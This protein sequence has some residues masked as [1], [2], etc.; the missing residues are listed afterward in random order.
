MAYISPPNTVLAGQAMT[1]D[2]LP[3]TVPAGIL[4]VTFNNDIATVGSLGVVQVGDNIS[5][6]AS[7]VISAAAPVPGPQGPTGPGGG[8]DGPQGPTGPSGPSGGPTGPEGPTGPSG[9]TGP[10]GVVGATGPQGP[11]G[12]S[13]AGATGPQGPQG[14]IGPTGPSGPSGPQGVVGATGPQGPT[15]QAGAQGPQGVQ[16]PSGANGS[17][18][19]Q[20]PTGQAGAQGP[21]G[22]SGAVGPTGPTASAQYG[23]FFDTTTQTNPVVNTANPMTLNSTGDTSGIS[24]VSGSRVTVTVTG[25]YAIVFTAS[26]NKTDGGADTISFWLA[27]NGIN[28]SNS[29][30]DL[31]LNSSIDTIFDTG[32]YLLSLAAGDYV[33]IF[34]SSADSAMRLLSEPAAPTPTRP[35]VPS[36]R[37]TIS[38]V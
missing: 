36:A 13:G 33:Q 20:G 24:V 17:T 6:T 12:P 19:P 25:T 18:G 9:A 35:A 23:Y 16:G 3:G 4:P 38:Q 29:R 28:V 32:N 7:G 26:V 1:Q 22:P 14:G 27:K 21:Q 30:Q 11:Q 31:I 2:P 37:I 34:W 15:G 5:V 8:A 10:Q